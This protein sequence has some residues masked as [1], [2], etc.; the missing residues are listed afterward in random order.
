MEA[1]IYGYVRDDLA[2]GRGD[3]WESAM[4]TLAS[5]AG[6]CFA[7]TFHESTPGDGTAFAELTAELK[8]ADAHHVVVPSLDH[9]AGQ[10]IPRDILIAKL[11]QEASAKV[12]TID[13]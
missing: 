12:W 1:L 3:E 2:D 10:T 9:L 6:F 8:R 5:S 13:S 7:A 4:C 11:A